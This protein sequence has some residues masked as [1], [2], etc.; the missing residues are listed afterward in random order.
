[1]KRIGGL[2]NVGHFHLSRNKRSL[3]KSEKS[4][5]EFD[6]TFDNFHREFKF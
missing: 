5:D 3:E 4:K 1:M 2:N 6:K